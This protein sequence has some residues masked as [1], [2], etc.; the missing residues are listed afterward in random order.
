MI[1]TNRY[2]VSYMAV[3]MHGHIAVHMFMHPLSLYG[4][5]YDKVLAS[6]TP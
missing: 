2:I 4:Q 1:D 5:M 3:C 6:K